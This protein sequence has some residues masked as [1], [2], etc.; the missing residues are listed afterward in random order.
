[1]IQKQSGLQSV[2]ESMLD[3]G[4]FLDDLSRLDTAPEPDELERAITAMDGLMQAF[5]DQLPMLVYRAI[6]A[7]ET[8]E[9]SIAIARRLHLSESPK[10]VRVSDIE[11]ALEALSL[12]SKET[13]GP[14]T[15]AGVCHTSRCRNAV[16]VTI[17]TRAE[18]KEWRE[19]QTIGG[20]GR[21][22]GAK[23]V[24][25]TDCWEAGA[26]E[27]ERAERL[28]QEQADRWRLER[29][30]EQRLRDSLPTMPYKEYLQTEHWKETRKG[31]LKRAG[32]KCQLCNSDLMLQVHHRTYERRGNEQARD[33][34]VLCQRCHKDFHKVDE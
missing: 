12:G 34:I 33:L 7:G 2:V 32:Y 4:A 9:D 19:H 31:A 21:N 25:C 1:M 18:M 3:I 28:R 20:A 29:E 24:V 13:L 8:A 27:R 16:Y 11:A 23:H 6:N 17:N 22:W 5:K 26:P 30:A 14:V 10:S 15:V